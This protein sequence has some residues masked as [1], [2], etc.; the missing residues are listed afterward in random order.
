MVKFQDW[1]IGN[2]ARAL[3]VS[4][5]YHLQQTFRRGEYKLLTGGS[6]LYIEDS[7]IYWLG[8]SWL[9]KELSVGVLLFIPV[10]V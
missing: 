10:I 4:M 3:K 9:K 5:I 2:I 6:V 8:L 7:F 1:C